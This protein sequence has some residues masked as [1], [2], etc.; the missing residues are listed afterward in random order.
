MT[1]GLVELL[2]PR[3]TLH[4]GEHALGLDAIARH[5]R[6]TTLPANIAGRVVTT[7]ARDPLE[8]LRYIEA[9]I[10]ADALPVPSALCTTPTVL[11]ARFTAI[12][13]DVLVL[14]TSGSTGA[15]RHAVFHRDAL[16]RSAALIAADL[17]LQPD[18]VV[19]LVLP[20]DHGF[21]LVGQLLA[22]AMVGARVQWAP[23]AFAQ[24]R[25]AA[26][27]AGGAT[28][29]AAVPFGLAQLLA[30][31]PGCASLPPLRQVGVAGGA[32]PRGLAEAALRTFPRVELVHQYG[33]TE[34]GPRLTSI[35]SRNPAFW[36]GSVGRA[37][38]GVSIAVLDPD[39]AG[40]GELTF[41]SPSAMTRYLEGA[42]ES[43][44][45][46]TPSASGRWL[47]TGDR[48]SVTADG[49]VFVTGRTDDVVKLR[50]EK[51]SL[52]SVARATEEAGAEDAI[53]CCLP[54]ES[55]DPDGILAVLYAG[56]VSLSPR[57]LARSLP[58]GVVVKR[59]RHVSQLPRTLSGKV[60]RVAAAQ[61]L[62]RT[63]DDH[64]AHRS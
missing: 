64:P 20:C 12:A 26:L 18:D 37:L 53:A 4:M 8:A 2:S 57:D 35:S 60:D 29:L 43:A 55:S 13:G 16:A 52:A 51:V 28:V 3:F 10:Q 23:G 9:C 14:R 15:P 7:P 38:P 63:A 49:L 47:R 59:L 1:A 54:S 46:G 34:A 31:L 39:D 19:G 33:C 41:A 11:D 42:V 58:R 44:Q 62:T 17:A 21:G 30:A 56:D 25:I 6:E 24:Q 22:A 36:T 48:G 50:G 32:L 5:A 40:E 45:A 61:L 27:A